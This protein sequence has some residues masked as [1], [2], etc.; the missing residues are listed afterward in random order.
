MV[1][2]DGVAEAQ[3]GLDTFAKSHSKVGAKAGARL[4]LRVAEVDKMAGGKMEASGAWPQPRSFP[5]L[6][7]VL[8]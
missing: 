1:A 6:F 3:R 5:S 8:T 4:N 7:L 2:R